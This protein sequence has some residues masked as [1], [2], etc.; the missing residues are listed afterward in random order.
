MR[1]V[2]SNV[3]PADSMH[4]VPGQPGAILGFYEIDAERYS[5]VFSFPLTS[6]PQGNLA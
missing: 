2:P 4:V 6:C 1:E 3:L 5:I